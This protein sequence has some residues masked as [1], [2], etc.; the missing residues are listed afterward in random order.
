MILI[1]SDKSDQ[2]ADRVELILQKNSAEYSRL[3]LDVDSVKS[4]HVLIENNSFRIEAPNC[5]FSTSQIDAVWNRSVRIDKL[6]DNGS[7]NQSNFLTDKED[8]NKTLEGL[9][10][11]LEST[12]WLNLYEDFYNG[13]ELSHDSPVRNIG[14]KWPAFICSNDINYLNILFK[15][16]KDRI[17][18]LM[19]QGCSIN[20]SEVC[21]VKC[22]DMIGTAS[23]GENPDGYCPSRNGTSQVRCSVVGKEYFV[24]RIKGKVNEK[25]QLIQTNSTTYS[26]IHPPASIKLKAIQILNELNLSFGVFDFIVTDKGEWLFD[27]LNP[28]GQYQWVEDMNAKDISSSIAKWLMMNN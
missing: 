7:T 21:T 6:V 24:G 12:K 10:S 20:T 25:G 8:W 11:S 13:R 26:E 27:A 2:H 23:S 28:M 5:S 16:K 22:I 3:N 17:L 9:Y 18:E 14:L 19:D 4:T 15:T 1:L